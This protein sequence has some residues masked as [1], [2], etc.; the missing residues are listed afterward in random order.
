M[1]GLYLVGELTH[2]RNMCVGVAET[3]IKHRSPAKIL[4][5]TFLFSRFSL[6]KSAAKVI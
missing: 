3:G 6:T 1:L 2:M 4:N 5:V